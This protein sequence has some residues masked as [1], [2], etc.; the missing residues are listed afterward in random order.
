MS[1]K[2]LSD[3]LSE[4]DTDAQ[5]EIRSSLPEAPPETGV[6]PE[7]PREEPVRDESGKFAPKEPKEAE[8]PSALPKDVYEPLRAVRDE[9]KALKDQL[10][11]LRREVQQKPQEPPAP[12]PTIWEDEQGTFQH[13]GRQF[14]QTAVEQAAFISRLQTSELLM[15]QAEPEFEKVKQDVYQFVG[16]NPAVNAEVQNSPHPWQTA[17]RAYKNQQTMQELGATDI[18]QLRE[19]IRAEIEAEMAAGKPAM[20]NI[21]PSLSSQRSVDGRSGPAWAGPKPLSDLLG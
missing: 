5:A 14:T 16:S 13:Y 12:P 21:P 8:P 20:P 1:R 6:E 15:M 10:E 3:I 18:N 7:E 2:S 9:N 4:E 17:Y 19:R 11:A